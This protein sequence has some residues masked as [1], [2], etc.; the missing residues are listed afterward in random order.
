MLR[1]PELGCDEDV[2]ALE[3]GYFAAKSLLERLRNLLLVAVDLGEIKVAVTSFERLE[4]GSADLTRLSLPC[5]KAQLTMNPWL[6]NV[7]N[8][9]P[10]STVLTGWW[11]QC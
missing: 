7:M 2:L 6:A 5:T 8:A 9:R 3:A 1:V 11:R 4:D 10:L